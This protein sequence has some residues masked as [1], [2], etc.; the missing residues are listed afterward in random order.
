MFAPDHERAAAELLRVCRP[1]GTIALAS[2]SPDSFIGELFR[3]TA[4]HVPPPAGLQPPGLWGTEDHVRSLFGDGVTD[5]RADAAHATR[6]ATA[7]RSTSWTSSATHYGPTH[8]AFAALDDAGREAL[9]ADLAELVAALRPPRGRGRGGGPGRLPGDRRDP[10]RLAPARALQ[11]ALGRLLAAVPRRVGQGRHDVE[12]HR[13]A[14]A[15]RLARGA[16]ELQ[17]HRGDPAG[18]GLAFAGGDLDLLLRPS[19]LP[20]LR[21]MSQRAA[22][23]CMPRRRSTVS[24]M[25]PLFTTFCSVVRARRELGLGPGVIAAGPPPAPPRTTAAGGAAAT[26]PGPSRPT[27]TRPG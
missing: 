5:L 15:E 11:A 4:Q 8:K 25:K 13:L 7:R 14:P 26:T 10:R 23:S 2:W 22:L 9:A 18:A 19:R 16:R 24:G 6:S 21:V 1:G 20:S 12:R 3:T 17:L 27:A